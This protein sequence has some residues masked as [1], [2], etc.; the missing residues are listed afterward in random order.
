MDPKYYVYIILLLHS[1]FNP[2]EAETETYRMTDHVFTCSKWL[3]SVIE[4]LCNNVYRIV[5]RDTSL[6]M[7][8][9]TPR[10]IQKSVNRRRFLAE[11]KWRRLRRQVATECCVEA[12]TI[13]NIILYCPENSKVIKENPHIFG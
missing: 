1:A 13:S 7:E 11:E 6:L 8:K 5:K 3:S 9:L 12:C 4:N 10:D 2:I